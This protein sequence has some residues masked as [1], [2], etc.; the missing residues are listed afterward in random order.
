MLRLRQAALL[1]LT[2]S[3]MACG[4][5]VDLGGNATSP[6]VLMNY[7]GVRSG[8]RRFPDY[9]SVNRLNLARPR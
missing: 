4:G 3:A 1:L 5:A 6:S 7:N 9:G 2:L 8:T